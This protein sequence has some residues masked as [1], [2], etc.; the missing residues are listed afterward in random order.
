MYTDLPILESKVFK[1]SAL[2][3]LRVRD[4][5]VHEFGRDLLRIACKSPWGAISIT[6]AFLGMCLHASS[7]STGFNKLFVKY[8]AEQVSAS[9]VFQF[10]SGIEELIHL[11]DRFLGFGMTCEWKRKC[12][13]LLWKL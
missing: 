12:R 9:G 13:G 10:S 11:E 3:D 4:I 2:L 6:I 1:L 7:N 8:S 5:L